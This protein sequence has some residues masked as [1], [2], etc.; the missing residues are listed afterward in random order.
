MVDSFYTREPHLIRGGVSYDER[1]SL[2]FCNDFTLAGAKRQYIVSNF[3]TK[4][5]RA[6]HGHRRE[7]KWVQ[8]VCGNAVVKAWAPTDDE[9]ARGYAVQAPPI[10]SRMY[11]YVL[12]P[13][14]L[15]HIPAGMANGW[16]ALTPGTFVQFFSD[17]ALSDAADDDIRFPWD[18]WPGVW[19]TPNQ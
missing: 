18:M 5:I 11:S 8:V 14:D 7:Q 2:A 12:R 1:G 4:T 16:R 17:T 10:E 15:L 6:W 9:F 13:G 3:E 19:E